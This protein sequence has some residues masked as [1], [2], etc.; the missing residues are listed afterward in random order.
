MATENKDFD[1]I[2]F[3]AY[4]QRFCAQGD[5]GFPFGTAFA[6]SDDNGANMEL[7]PDTSSAPEM[8]NGR[9]LADRWYQDELKTAKTVGE[10]R[11]RLG[12]LVGTVGSDGEAGKR[13]TEI[14]ASVDKASDGG[15]HDNVELQDQVGGSDSVLGM[16]KLGTKNSLMR[17]DQLNPKQVVERTRYTADTLLHENSEEVGHAGQDAA[18]AATITIVDQDGLHDATTVFEGDVVEGVAGKLGQRRENLP[19]KTYIEGADAVARIGRDKVRSYTAKGG[20]NVGKHLQT[21]VW[22]Q[23]LGITFDEMLR[24]GTAVGM[25]EDQVYKAAR[26]LGKLPK[27]SE[28]PV[29]LAA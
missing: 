11:G 19:Q 29:A 17:R 24:Q 22:R 26:E 10:V 28:T 4:A 14:K 27:E 23:N 9:D 1:D 18:A 3:L 15:A 13:M 20:A 25:S 7:T 2:V 5:F 21:E 8:R 16:N 6:A 12:K